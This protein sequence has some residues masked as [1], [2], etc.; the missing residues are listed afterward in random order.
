MQ[1][2]NCPYCGYKNFSFIEERPW[3]PICGY[4]KDDNS[5]IPSLK[6][7]QDAKIANNFVEWVWSD[8]SLEFFQEYFSSILWEEILQKY[9]IKH[10]I[11]GL[12][13]LIW[14]YK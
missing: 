4:I 11:K 14:E 6:L 5:T 10:G 13:Y 12:I 3:C 2:I 9:L 8:Y 7:I 1:D